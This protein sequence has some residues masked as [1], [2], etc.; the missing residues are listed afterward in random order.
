MCSCGGSRPKPP[1]GPVTACKPKSLTDVISK[2]PKLNELPEK[3]AIPDEVCK[4][5]QENWKKSIDSSGNSKEHGGTV[6]LDKNGKMVIV[7]EGSGGSGAF[8]PSKTVPADHTYKGTFHTHPYG[9]NDG[10][11]DGAH[12][13]FSSGDI[14][15]LQN[16]YNED[17]SLLQS[18]NNK[19]VIVKTAESETIDKA[20]IEKEIEK[21]FDKE[22]DK[23]IKAGKKPPEAAEIA[24][25]KATGEALKK[26]KYGYYKGTDCASLSRVNP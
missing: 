22:Y 2:T 16:P 9:K 14:K 23:Q 15:T 6:A 7:N 8:S 20:K 5:M 17:V 12:T 25:E 24:Q 1:S 13:T 11:W 26:L 19:Y 4:K 18:G 10:D 3:I 21:S